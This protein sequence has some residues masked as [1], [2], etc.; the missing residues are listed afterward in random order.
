MAKEMSQL[1]RDIQ[2]SLNN[3]LAHAGGEM[4]P[5]TIEP[6]VMVRVV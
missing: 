1:A 6:V 4:T 3:A 5:G 2:E